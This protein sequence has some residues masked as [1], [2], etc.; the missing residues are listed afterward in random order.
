[1]SFST[2]GMVHADINVVGGV[3]IV[4]EQGPTDAIGV[5]AKKEEERRLRDI[6][7]LAAEVA[8]SAS[9]DFRREVFKNASPSVVG[10]ADD[11]DDNNGMGQ[12]GTNS[13]V[14][15]FKRLDQFCRFAEREDRFHCIPHQRSRT[16][17]C[18]RATM[19]VLCLL[20]TTSSSKE[21]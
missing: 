9:T 12:A 8:N 14:A 6:P 10:P 2:L 19:A 7:A 3:Q 4:T 5:A 13:L 15:S 21:L 1:M 18:F 20:G 11:D 16:W 17:A